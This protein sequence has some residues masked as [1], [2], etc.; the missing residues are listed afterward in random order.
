[1]RCM[2]V[3]V[4]AKGLNFPT[5]SVWIQSFDFKSTPLFHI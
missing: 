3:A 4:S 2:H 5:S 1:M